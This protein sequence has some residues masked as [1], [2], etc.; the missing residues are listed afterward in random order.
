MRFKLLTPVSCA[1][2]RF[3]RTL[4]SSAGP[5]V[6]AALR[7]GLFSNYS[8]TG[9]QNPLSSRRWYR[10]RG[11][12]HGIPGFARGHAAAEG[13]QRYKGLI[14]PWRHLRLGYDSGLPGRTLGEST[15]LPRIRWAIPAL[16]LR[17]WGVSSIPQIERVP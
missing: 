16:L 17:L 15:L 12:G 14:L 10:Q 8:Q 1:I 11:S 3:L 13:F 7:R 5:C 4:E 6:G 2:A 9:L